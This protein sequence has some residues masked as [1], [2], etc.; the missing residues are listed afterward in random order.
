[1]QSG[2][3]R[4]APAALPGDQLKARA[5]P[6]N[7]ERLHDAGGADGSRQFLQRLFA[8]SRARLK[9]AGIDQV[10]INLQKGFIRCQGRRYRRRCCSPRRCCRLLLRRLRFL[11]FRIPDQS[12]QSPAQRVSGHSR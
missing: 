1:M 7:H 10:S 2:A 6:A 3:L 5:H 11:W 9:R 4:G 12:A 8:K